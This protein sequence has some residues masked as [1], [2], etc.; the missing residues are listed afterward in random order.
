MRH[1]ATSLVALAIASPAMADF[2]SDAAAPYQ[3]VTIRGVS[4]STPPSNY[5]RDVLAPQFTEATGIQ[6]EFETT[7]WDQM[8]D[9]AIKDMEAGSGIYD[10]VYIE[11]DAIYSYLSRDFLVD[12]TQMMADNPAL[13]N[14]AFDW[15]NFTTFIDYFKDPNKNDHVFGVPMEAFIKVYLYR[16]DLFEN[17][18]IQASFQEKYGYDLAPATTFQQW[19]DIAEFFT[20]YGQE[21][22][23][24]LYGTTVQAASGHPASFYEFWESVAPLYGVYDWGINQETWTASVANGGRMNSPEAVEALTFWLGL[25]QYAPPEA[26]ASTWDE[27][28]SSFAAGRAAQGLVYG[29]NATWIATNAEK[30]SVVGNVGVALPPTAEGV[31]EAAQSG[32]GYIGY[33]DG[34]AFGIPH[35]SANKEAALLFMQYIA[36]PELQAGWAEAGGRIVLNSTYEDPKVQEIDAKTDSYFTLMKDS[37]AL[38]AGAPPYP[39]HNQVREVSAPFIYEAIIGNLTPQEALDQMAAATEAE[40]KN[41]GYTAN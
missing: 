27:V 2:W 8:Y 24:E 41:L 1:L 15:A 30:S 9:K 20:A 26:T 33:Y 3:G 34:G 40:L 22:G 36:Q 32:E 29:E 11:Q 7:S 37:G 35:S 16:K 6:V 23:Q 31:M 25:L 17:P 28:A 5:V 12:M 18:E 14:P 4:E 13:V 39:F 21:T 19:R 38:F 10:F